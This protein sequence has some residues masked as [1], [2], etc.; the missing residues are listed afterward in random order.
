MEHIDFVLA[1]D[2]AVAALQLHH[3]RMTYGASVIRGHQAWSGADLRGA[4]KR[5]GSYAVARRCARDAW[6]T[7]GGIV[8][9]V[10]PHGRLTALLPLSATQAM[11]Q[12]GDIYR[13]DETSRRWVKETP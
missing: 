3:P 4:A 1:V 2:A 8:A 10:A 9:P 6:A 5:H 12:T 13:R 11:S 7:V